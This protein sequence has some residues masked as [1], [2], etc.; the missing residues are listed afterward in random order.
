MSDEQL[1]RLRQQGV[2]LDRD[3]RRLLET[4]ANIALQGA[5]R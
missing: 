3:P 4:V 2:T 5:G 1:G